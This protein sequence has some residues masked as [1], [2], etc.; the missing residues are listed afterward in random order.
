MK[1]TVKLFS[2]IF[3]LFGLGLLQSQN[4][5]ISSGGDLSGVGGTANYTLG[6]AIY[7]NTS[8]LDGIVVQTGV[9]QVFENKI[10]IN[11]KGFL[12]GPYDTFNELMTDDLR[13]SGLIPATSP[14]TDELTIDP[15]VLNISGVNA[16]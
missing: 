11:L 3:L 10:E 12:Q 5:V 9:Q 7:N 15:S 2:L 4:A 6:Q 1:N 14:Y 8:S 16:C 13:I